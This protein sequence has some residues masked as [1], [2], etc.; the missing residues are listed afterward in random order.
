MSQPSPVKISR[1][2]FEN[3]S[4]AKTE[5]QHYRWANDLQSNQILYVDNGQSRSESKQ[6]HLNEAKSEYGRTEERSVL[7]SGQ[8]HKE[9]KGKPSKAKMQ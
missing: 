4:I 2:I 8:I 5:G 9:A 7:E 6:G 1:S 3:D